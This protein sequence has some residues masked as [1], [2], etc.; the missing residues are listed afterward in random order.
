[1][2][3]TAVYACVRALAEAFSSLLLQ[4]NRY[5]DNGKEK[6]MDQYLYYILHS[7]PNQ[8]QH[9]LHLKTFRR[10]SPK[11]NTAFIA[12]EGVLEAYDRQLSRFFVHENNGNLSS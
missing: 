7:E 10:I 9:K 3:T 11:H 8:N 12:K 5:T 4:T 2:Q 6:A 1:M